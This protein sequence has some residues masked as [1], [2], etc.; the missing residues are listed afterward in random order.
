MQKQNKNQVS[1]PINEIGIVQKS[2]E[3]TSAVKD[4][5]Q[6]K[7]SITAGDTITP[8]LWKEQTSQK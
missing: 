3:T 8:P 1:I 7:P 2:T 5:V 4:E 6:K